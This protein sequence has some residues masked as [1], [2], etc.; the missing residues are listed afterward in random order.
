VDDREGAAVENISFDALPTTRIAD[1]DAAYVAGRTPTA[2]TPLAEATAKFLKTA[3]D[4]GATIA[5]GLLEPES[6]AED[7]DYDTL[8]GLLPAVD[9]L[10]AT[11]AAV[12][13]VFDRTG[14][15][16][17]LTHALAADHDFE[18]VALRR[19]Q[20]GAVWRD[21]TVHEYS[22]PA[23]ETVD[24]TGAADAFAG[25]FLVGLDGADV[26]TAIRHAIAADALV[27]T[28]PGALPVFLREELEAV[29]ASLERP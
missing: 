22:L 13:A 1:A 29:A 2:S 5:L 4:G 12:E 23:V 17:Q 21:S 19:E 14:E 3:R 6:V 24:V 28:T 15:P 9:V 10:I 11:P 8:E 16:T 25:A 20:T 7:A 26:Q 27:K 18:T